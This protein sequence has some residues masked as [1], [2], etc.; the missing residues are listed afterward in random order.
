MESMPLQ[1]C[2]RILLV[3]VLGRDEQ[4][5]FNRNVGV[6][7][8][9]GYRLAHVH[10]SIHSTFLNRTR[11]DWH[12]SKHLLPVLCQGRNLDLEKNVVHCQ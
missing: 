9:S 1:L 5:K 4:V 8:F 7:L 11:D 12:H 3:D 10:W 6:K 2:L